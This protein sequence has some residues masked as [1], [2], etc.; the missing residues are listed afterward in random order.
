M[1][2]PELVELRKEF[3]ELIEAYFDSSLQGTTPYGA[4]V[5]FQKKRE[6][7]ALIIGRST[8]PSRTSIHFDCRLLR[9]NARYFSK[10]DLR[11]GYY[12]VRIA[13]GDEP[14]TTRVTSKVRCV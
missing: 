7:C 12:Q 8:Q 4:P 9:P 14:K 2:L 11:L 1:A 3:Q 13:E 10:L 5:L 6:P